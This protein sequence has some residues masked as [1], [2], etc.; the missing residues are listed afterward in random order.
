MVDSTLGSYRF[1]VGNYRVIFDIE[2]D[3]IV[4]LNVGKRDEIYKD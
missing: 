3:E 1:R 2:K 4:I